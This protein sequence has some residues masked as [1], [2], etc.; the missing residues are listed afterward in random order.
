[1]AR[2]GYPAARDRHRSRA[3][4]RASGAVAR[5]RRAR[6]EELEALANGEI[7]RRLR[8]LPGIGPWTASVILLRG[9]RRLD[10]FPGGDVAAARGLGAIAGEHGGELVEALGPYRGMLYFHLLLSSLAARRFGPSRL[11]S[12]MARPTSR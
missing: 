1:V 12:W 5:R 4:L 7:E 6:E 8:E 2:P 3:I 9:F 11:A 10:V